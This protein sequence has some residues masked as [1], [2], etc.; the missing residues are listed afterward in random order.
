MKKKAQKIR[1]TQKS[2]GNKK[3]MGASRKKLSIWRNLKKSYPIN[4]RRPKVPQIS[5]GARFFG[6]AKN[7][8]RKST[9][10]S[11]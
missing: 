2:E 8:H 4:K 6:L 9:E 10:I 1:K 5:A 11:T 7:N 3:K